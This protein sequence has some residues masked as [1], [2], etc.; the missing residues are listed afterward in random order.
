MYL[1]NATGLDDV[2][3]YGLTPLV[4]LMHIFEDDLIDEL[5]PGS[6]EFILWM[7]MKGKVL[8][9]REVAERIYQADVTRRRQ[10]RGE[11]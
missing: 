3:T 4:E 8:M 11:N 6:Q 1:N 10:D 5:K 7:E 9:I 2:I